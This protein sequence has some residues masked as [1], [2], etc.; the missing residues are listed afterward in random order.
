MNEIE[1]AVQKLK[2]NEVVAVPT[3]TVYGLAARIS[4]EEAILKIFKTKARPFF[5]PLIVHVLNAKQAKNFTSNWTEIHQSLAE[6]FWPGPLTLILPKK[7]I[8][9]LITSGL[10]TVGIRCPNHPIALKIIKDLGEPFAAPSANK[11]GKTSPTNADHVKTEFQ[12]EVFVVDGG[13]SNIGIESTI[14][15]IVEKSETIEI[16]MHRAGK[17]T[18]SQLESSLKKYNKKIVFL[19]PSDSISAPGQVKHHY[20]PTI[21]IIWIS[22]EKLIKFSNINAMVKD[23]TSQSY[24]NP[25]IMNLNSDA[26]IAAR[27]LYSQMRECSK[28][29]A[30]I[31]IC[32]KTKNQIGELWESIHDR[33]NR[34]ST[35]KLI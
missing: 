25:V 15:E 34:A 4:S 26:T 29:P 19:N 30:D 32:I 6:D 21:P 33:L 14:I 28:Y 24:L 18:K 11:F 13:Q 10:P 17:I 16:I 35:Y 9:D 12:N 22:E 5:D 7:N 31:I 3:E 23:F 27:E 20:M 8:S 1:I 2:T